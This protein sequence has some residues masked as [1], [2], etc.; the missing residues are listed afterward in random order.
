MLIR[1]SIRILVLLAAGLLAANSMTQDELPPQTLF[2]NV[3]VWDGKSDGITRRINVLVEDNLIKKIRAEASDA[4]AEATV[5]DAPG[6]ILMPGLISSHVHL[7]HSLAQGGVQGFEAM[8]CAGALSA[9]EHGAFNDASTF[10]GGEIWAWHMAEEIE[11]RSVAF[12]VFDHL[13][14]SY[15][16][17]IVFGTRAQ[18]HYVSYIRRFASCMA[19]ALGRKLVAPGDEMQRTAR[20]N[21]LRTWSPWYDPARIAVPDSVDALLTRYSLMSQTSEAAP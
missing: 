21:Y 1:N 8:T 20:R 9:A 11:H 18:W 12:G 2:T 16:Y 19:K 6:K 15:F 5:I 4:H 10:P 17:R 13:V 3:H 14:G 7:T